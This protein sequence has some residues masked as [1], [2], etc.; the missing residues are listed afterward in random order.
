L[1]NQDECLLHDLFWLHAVG[2]VIIIM[3]FWLLKAL[4]TKLRFRHVMSKAIQGIIPFMILSFIQAM[5]FCY[6]SVANATLSIF[7]C[8]PVDA[9]ADYGIGE[10]VAATGQRWV[11]VGMQW[12]QSCISLS[13]VWKRH[14]FCI[15]I[16]M[17]ARRGE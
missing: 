11:L 17:I 5:L 12:M 4:Y 2:Y 14:G 7:Q 13:K 1:H 10:E 9:P 3:S 16:I 6:P 15:I 8:G